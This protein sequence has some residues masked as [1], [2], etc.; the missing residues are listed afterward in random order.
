V[1]DNLGRASSVVKG[2]FSKINVSNDAADVVPLLKT[3]L[4][5]VEMTEK[6]LGEVTFLVNCQLSTQPHTLLFICTF[7]IWYLS[8]QVGIKNHCSNNL[9]IFWI[10][11]I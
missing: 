5:G 10:S 9:M 1:A 3:L 8:Y 6:Q 11:G 7:C 2:N 4:E